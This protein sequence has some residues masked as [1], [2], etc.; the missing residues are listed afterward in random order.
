MKK[1]LADQLSEEKP[2]PVGDS[3]HVDTKR[4]GQFIESLSPR[5]CSLEDL[6]KHCKVDRNEW[7]IERFVVNKW[8]VG[9][10]G[11][12][13]KIVV[14]P[15]FQVKAWLKKKTGWT[16]SEF[17]EQLIASMRKHAPRYTKPK[18]QR[19]KG[20]RLMYEVAIFDHHVG[21]LCWGKETGHDYDIDIAE[22]VYMQAVEEL[23]SRVQG[24]QIESI[25]YPIGNDFL[26]TDNARGTTTRGTPQDVDG[27]W[28]KAFVHARRMVISATD[29]MR[30]IAPVKIVVVAGNHDLERM[31]YLGDSVECWYHRDTEVEVDN[32]PTLRKYV[33]YGINL[34][35][36][37]HGSEERHA[38][39]PR[40]MADEV[41]KLW[42]NSH[43]R[44]IHLG[45]FHKQKET[46]F[47][48]TDTF[49]KTVVRI[50]PSLSGTDSWHKSKGY[51]S[52]RCS[53]GH[54]WSFDRGHVGH[55]LAG[56]IE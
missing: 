55:F 9:A 35:G 21:K 2:A 56:I 30:E 47:V 45:H 23:L 31:F 18:R 27:R 3:V 4:D 40:L 39:L 6:L 20:E 42:A 51:T 16:P 33:P 52:P 24:Q 10:R 17:R 14:E 26:H 13:K 37:T 50:L 7:D 46:V 25:L 49:G 29:R 32:A 54:L 41:P 15:L 12:D 19:T 38:E 11:P 5:I 44:E 34:L 8:E 43:H 28:Q 36:F 1:D 53:E 22:S 48:T